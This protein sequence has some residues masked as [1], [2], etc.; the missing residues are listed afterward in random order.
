MASR[1]PGQNENPKG[2]GKTISAVAR[3]GNEETN[4][5]SSDNWK[6]KITRDDYLRALALYTVAHEHY[7]QSVRF[8]EAL[9]KI[10]MVSPEKYPGGHV[11]DAIYADEG[12]SVAIFD[13]A[14]KREEIEVENA[15]S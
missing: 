10:I 9:N 1:S 3:T 5:K 12:G 4:M 7:V 2:S 15:A 13:E 11:D 6:P 8:A 14:L